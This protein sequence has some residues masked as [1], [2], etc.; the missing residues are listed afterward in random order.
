[1]DTIFDYTT[2]KALLRSIIGVEMTKEEY[3]EQTTEQVRVLHLIQY[4]EQ[5]G[6]KQLLKKLRKKE[7][8]IFN[9]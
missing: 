2:D 6:D 7:A 8:A 9:E 3:L 5:A 1:M 4:A